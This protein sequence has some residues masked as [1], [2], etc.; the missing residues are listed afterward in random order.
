MIT[1]SKKELKTFISEHNLVFGAF[2]SDGIEIQELVSG[3]IDKACPYE[4][5][6]EKEALWAANG[7]G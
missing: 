5:M 1:I 6:M 4:L 2:D 7:V 3:S